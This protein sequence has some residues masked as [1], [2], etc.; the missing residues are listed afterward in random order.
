MAQTFSKYAGIIQ[1]LMGALS[2]FVPGIGT[3][4]GSA[5]GGNILNIIMG[6][7]LSYFGFK[8]SDSQ[9]RMGAQVVGGLSGLM[10]LLGGFGVNLP[11]GLDLSQGWS[12]ANI[13]N[14]LVGAWGLY[15]GFAKKTAGAAAH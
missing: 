4:L 11:M 3:M 13:V 15:S 14:L 6:L 8:G 7:V 1:V 5:Q 2:Q 10:G 9:Q 12:G